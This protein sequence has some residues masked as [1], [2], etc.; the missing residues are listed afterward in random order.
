M[1]FLGSLKAGSDLAWHV[2]GK[3]QAI[4]CVRRDIQH[5]HETHVEMP[6]L[7]NI[8]DIQHSCVLVDKHV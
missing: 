4:V 5:G 6:M 3:R 8:K 2:P 7:Q 1:Q